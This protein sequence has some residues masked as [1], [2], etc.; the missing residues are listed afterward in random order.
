L[1]PILSFL[2]TT[3]QASALYQD[4]SMYGT[5]MQNDSSLR[6]RMSVR[7][8]IQAISPPSRSDSADTLKATAS[9]LARGW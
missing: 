6:P 2:N 5:S 3:I 8:V 4:G 7:T 9:E 1:P